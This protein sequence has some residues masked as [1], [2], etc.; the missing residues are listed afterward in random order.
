M[1]ESHSQHKWTKTLANYLYQ[2]NQCV[3]P[4]DIAQFLKAWAKDAASWKTG[5]ISA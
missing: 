3:N 2:R 1:I 5:F 4:K